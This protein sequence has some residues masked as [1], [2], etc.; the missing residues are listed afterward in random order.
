MMICETRSILIRIKSINTMIMANSAIN[1][2]CLAIL[3]FLS[4]RTQLLLPIKCQKYKKCAAETTHR[5]TQF[6]FCCDTVHIRRNDKQSL[7]FYQAQTS[8]EKMFNCVA[9]L[10]YY[11]L[12]DISSTI[13]DFICFGSVACAC[14]FTSRLRFAKRKSK[15]VNLA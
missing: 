11:I 14:P 13:K 5:K 1:I 3:K 7:R 8:D 15:A 10:L 2:F 9:R 6:R 4:N 12:S